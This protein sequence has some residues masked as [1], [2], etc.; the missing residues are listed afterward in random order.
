MLSRS[1]SLRARSLLAL[2]SL[3]CAGLVATSQP[4]QGQTGDTLVESPDYAS[5]LFGD[6]WDFNNPEDVLLDGG[7]Q[8]DEAGPTRGMQDARVQGGKLRFAMSGPGY[9]SPVWGG[10]P[11]ALYLG[12]E[13]SAPERQVDASRF[14]RL[15]FH[16]Y[17]SQPSAAG[18]QWFGCEGLD[19]DCWGGQPFLARQGW[20][21]Y[22]ILLQNQGYGLPQEWAGKIHG[23]RLALS[24][25]GQTDFEVEW[26]RLYEPA[27]TS[28]TVP[29]RGQWDV[30]D[31]GGD[32]VAHRPGWGN[33]N[34]QLPACDLSFLPAGTYYTRESSSA[35]HQGPL[36]VLR[37]A[38][39]VVLDPDEVGGPD[40]AASD[41]WDFS[42]PTDVGHMGNA[43]ALEIGPRLVAVNDGPVINDP[44]V[45]L[46]LRTPS[47]DPFRFHRLTVRS[48][49]E[50]AFDLRDEPGGGTMGRFV[51]HHS[52][53]P[54]QTQQ[55]NDLVTYG[56]TRTLT[57]DLAQEGVHET[58]EEA[59]DSRDWHSGDVSGVRWDPNE[60]RAA[61][62][63]WVER[64]ALRADDEAGTSFDV[65]W[66]DTGFAPG[67][68]VRLY[69]EDD[70]T[71]ENRRLISGTSPIA[72]RPGTNVFRWDTSGVREGWY[73]VL[74]EVDGPAGSA[75]ATSTGPV[76]V[77]HDIQGQAESPVVPLPRHLTDACPQSRV[78][79]SRLPDVPP[80]GV[81]TSSIDCIAWWG[82][83]AAQASGY[84]PTEL[85]T[86]G[87]MASFLR[88]VVEST[89]GPLPAG[90]DAFPDDTGSVHEPAI[91]ALAAAGALGGYADGLYRPDEPVNRAQMATFLTR[92]AERVAGPLPVT[93]DFFG[94][95]DGG[96]HETSIDKAAGSG[97]AGGTAEGRYSPDGL[98]R[99]DSMA[100]FLAR[101]LDLLV[102]AGKGSPPVR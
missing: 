54:D 48:G 30:N 78:P 15:S 18:V 52:D 42:A 57:V 47:I 35:A 55:T 100:S 31:T 10:Y 5:E 46:P 97:I 75:T 34:C 102:Q 70:G 94:D 73:R 45:Y 27:P 12:R 6:P 36:R 85:V 90:R 87:Q 53:D 11:G 66:V 25:G 26:M 38:R 63:W 84:A 59:G 99:R 1:A 62:R 40:H 96:T 49:Y 24:P 21:T 29:P 16:L 80:A 50:G 56:G 64:I 71:G 76:R 41:P 13:A 68:T 60:D 61:R 14:T 88:R 74:V 72:Q 51:W 83:T 67:S 101:T 33:V 9:F 39:P 77:R 95:D 3:L 43:R 2:S 23:L 98:V 93:A 19:P 92:I 82:V 91:D 37:R 7:I 44:H 81:H 17:A 28:T 8:A 22:N 58:D 69:V 20:N 89:A 32:N 65:R 79:A 86:R 4:A